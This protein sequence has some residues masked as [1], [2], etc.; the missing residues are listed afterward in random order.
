LSNKFL[1]SKTFQ[2]KMGLYYAQMGDI[3]R[4]PVWQFVGVVISAIALILTLIIERER[5][6][7]DRP[8]QYL[9]QII[10]RL[11]SVIRKPTVK[12]AFLLGGASTALVLV[13][14]GAL[15]RLI[16]T[17]GSPFTDVPNPTHPATSTFVST[18]I[19]SL[20]V[21]STPTADTRPTSSATQTAVFI[22]TST[23]PL[24]TTTPLHL[25]GALGELNVLVPEDC[26]VLGYDIKLDGEVISS[27]NTAQ[28]KLVNEGT[29]DITL[30]TRFGI[31]P[32]KSIVIASD[33]RK[34][35][36]FSSELSGLNLKSYPTLGQPIN[37]SLQQDQTSSNLVSD[38]NQCGAPG[39]YDIVFLPYSYYN[40]GFFGG[41]TIARYGIFGNE[42]VSFDVIVSSDETK[43][44]TPN[45]WPIQVGLLSFKSSSPISLTITVYKF[46]NND[47]A[48]FEDKV[49]L[50]SAQRYW[51]LPGRYKIVITD[52]FVNVSNDDVVITAGDEKVI[53]LPSLP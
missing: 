23:T 32:T 38:Y 26:G 14:I 47:W 12:T 28:G 17:S 24:P 20:T 5:I 18:Q 6:V 16:P 9:R 44:L 1:N 51:M 7:A 25:S 22:A 52:P 21:T 36:D 4:D 11:I 27:G 40:T 48:K 45:D 53:E 49:L 33:E 43:I 19:N 29:Y 39:T 3:L 15:L 42:L 10:A 50:N 46:V 31:A 30:K 41:G 2:Y 35:V 37:Y 13:L 34:I 8:N